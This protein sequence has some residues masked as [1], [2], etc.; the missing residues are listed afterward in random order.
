M[1]WKQ[2]GTAAAAAVLL[3]AFAGCGGPRSSWTFTDPQSPPSVVGGLGDQ[4]A[5]AKQAA[6]VAIARRN[7]LV[8]QG[9]LVGSSQ[10]T[11]GASLTFALPR[12]TDVDADLPQADIPPDAP[13][14][15]TCARPY[16]QT[17]LHLKASGVTRLYVLVDLHRGAV[18]D[19]TTNASSGRL[20][21]VR[22]KPHPDC[23]EIASG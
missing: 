3:L 4:L 6:A 8:A 1:T 14:K 19:V 21:W 9:R 17:W 2:H 13:A 5:P 16:R 11:Q 10:W 15:G 20:S 23:R 12:P 18:A 7:P 22:G